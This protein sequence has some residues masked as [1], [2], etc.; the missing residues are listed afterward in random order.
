MEPVVSLV[1]RQRSAVGDATVPI[2]SLRAADS[3]AVYS[4]P[5]VARLLSLSLGSTYALLREGEIPAR[6]LGG[7]WVIPKKRFHA[8]L[9]ESD[10]EGWA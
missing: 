2:R 5:E 6:K 3:R 4:V 9:D 10:S 1:P 8:W 7:R